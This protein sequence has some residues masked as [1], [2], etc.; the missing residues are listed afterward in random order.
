MIVR[1]LG[2]G[3][4]R[5]DSDIAVSLNTIDEALDEDLQE[6]HPQEFA[7]HLTEMQRLVRVHGQPLE[8]TELLPSDAILPAEGST[9]E[10]VRELLTADGLVPG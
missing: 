4:F 9:L 10:E 7:S 5:I 8:D 3:Q 1:I 2:E 6:L